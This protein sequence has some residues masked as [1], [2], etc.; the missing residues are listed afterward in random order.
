MSET[1]GPEHDFEPVPGLPAQLPAGETVLWQGRPDQAAVLRHVVRIR[2]IMAYFVVTAIWTVAV[3]I[4]DGTSL[5]VILASLTWVATA[6]LLVFALAWLF[7]R[8]VSRTSLYTLTNKRIVM[9]IGIALSASFNLPF[10]QIVSASIRPG[11][12]DTGDIALGLTPGHGLTSAV[13][14]PHQKGG[15]WRP[16]EPQMLCVPQVERVAELL[17]DVLEAS[18]SESASERQAISA[19]IDVRPGRP[20]QRPVAPVP[21]E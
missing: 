19:T 4:N 18:R 14:W 6:G 15:V 16:L 5:G 10:T 1:G 12:K 7:A 13:F 11:M 20:A 17:A 21:A 3:G 2:W 9:R 8:G